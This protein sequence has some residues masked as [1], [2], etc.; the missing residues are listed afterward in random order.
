MRP[1]KPDLSPDIDLFRNRLDNM[2][3]QRHELCRLADLIDWH[4][5]DAM[6]GE[7]YCADNGCPAKAIPEVS[8]HR[9]CGAGALQHSKSPAMD[10][11]HGGG[12]RRRRL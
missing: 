4:N 2:I 7:L 6:F 1:N 8:R 10:R 12:K 11:Q 3:D 9:R 5:F